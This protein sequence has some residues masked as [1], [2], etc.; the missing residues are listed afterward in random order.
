MAPSADEFCVALSTC[1]DQDTAGKLAR[2]LVEE[3]IVA[4]ATI[5]PGARSIYRWRGAV[6]EDDEVLLLMKTKASRFAELAAAIAARHPYETPE[7]VALPLVAA[8][9]PY[10]EWLAATL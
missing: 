10:L 4:C 3:G 9:A 2:I 6:H 1:P 5:V 8:G 7:I